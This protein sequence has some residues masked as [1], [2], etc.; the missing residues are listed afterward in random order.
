MW[1]GLQRI[2]ELTDGKIINCKDFDGRE[3]TPLHFAAG[4]NRVE[5]L[6]YLLENGAD[7]EARDT[8]WLVPLHNACAYGH[9]VVAELLVKHGADLNAVDKWGYTPLHECALKGKFEVCKMLLLSGAD[10]NHK[11]RD[12]KIP[13]DV[14]REGAEDVKDLLRGDEAVLEA[15][16]EGDVEKIRKIGGLIPLHNASSFGHLEIA[17][18]LIEYGAEGRT[19]ICSLLLNSG[20][21]VTL[22][23]TEGLTA[24][25]MAGAEDTKELLM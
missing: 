21:D 20:A 22:K 5:V 24:L 9:L 16:K 15:A 7:I 19:Q 2:I 6:K 13:L 3:S 14:V 23:N 17:V 8:G 1:N 12:G 18:L 10:R 25:D 4:Y 11:G